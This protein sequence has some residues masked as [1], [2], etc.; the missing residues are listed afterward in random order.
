MIWIL[1]GGSE[2]HFNFNFNWQSLILIFILGRGFNFNLISIDLYLYLYLISILIWGRD[3]NLFLISINL[4]YFQIF[5][6][7]GGF[8]FWLQLIFFI[9][10]FNW[11]ILVLV[12]VLVGGFNWSYLILFLID[13]FWSLFCLGRGIQFWFQSL[14]IN[15]ILIFNLIGGRGI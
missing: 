6:G 5:C 13:Q 9:L 7:S 11:S 3:S 14:N 4:G 12:L 1:I 15:L 2:I 8:L 10:F